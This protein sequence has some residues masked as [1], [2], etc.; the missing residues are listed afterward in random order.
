MSYNAVNHG[1]LI[2][3]NILDDTTGSTYKMDGCFDSIL[4]R[5]RFLNDNF[6]LYVANLRTTEEMRNIMRDDDIRLYLRISYYNISTSQTA[7]EL[8][9]NEVA[10]A[11]IVFDGIIRIY[12][13]PF[14]TTAAKVDDDNSDGITQTQS[15]PF[16]NYSLTGI[17]ENLIEKNE[18]VVNDIFADAELADVIVYELSNID[19]TSNMYIQ[20]TVN[21]T[22]YSDILLPPVSIIPA[23]KFLD[24]TYHRIYKHD[25]AFFI[26]SNNIYLYDPISDDTPMTNYLEINVVTTEATTDLTSSSLLKIDEDNNLKITYRKMPAF[27]INDEITTHTLGDHTVYYYYDENF[28]LVNR[29]RTNEK[30]YPKTRYLWE[31]M[32]DYS[33][34]ILDKGISMSL[35]FSNINPDLINPLT[36]VKLISSEYKQYEGQFLINELSY[37]FSSKDNK[38]FENTISISII[39]K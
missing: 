15:A 6:P 33:S 19:K 31:K 24:T 36:R 18:T 38:H 7:D 13:K 17:P 27:S 4:V 14:E 16:V 3:G 26:D 1:F 2:T 39:K 12:E 22:V 25:A 34:E 8:D 5:K 37:M 30:A 29:D 20:E 10:E 32:S 35:I 21:K 28:N 11:G 23:I 9:T